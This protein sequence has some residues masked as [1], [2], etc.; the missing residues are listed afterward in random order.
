MSTSKK[1]YYYF[2]DTHSAGEK[3]AIVQKATNAVTRNGFTSNYQTIKQSA[4]NILKIRG[5][6]LDSDLSA[7]SL[8]STYSNIPS[9]FHEAIVNR[10][11]AMGYKDPRN[12]DLKVAQYFDNEWEKAVRRAKKFSKSNYVSIGRIVAQD[13]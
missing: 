7:N 11:I 5:S 13:F 3:I 10:V 2:I 4:D 1:E 9:R 6:W 8:T 12:M